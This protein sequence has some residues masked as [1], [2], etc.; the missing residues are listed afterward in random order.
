MDFKR[1]LL[2]VMAVILVSCGEKEDT[3]IQYASELIDAVQVNVS[4]MTASFSGTYKNISKIDVALGRQGILYCEK[5]SDAKELFKSWTEGNLRPECFMMD[6]VS[7]NGEICTGLIGSLMPDTEYSYCFFFQNAD[8]SI[9]KISDVYVFRT[10]LFNPGINNNSVE[11]IHYSD[12]KARCNLSINEADF[13]YITIGVEVSEQ[14]SSSDIAGKHEYLFNGLFN[15]DISVVLDDLKENTDYSFRFFVKYLKEAGRYEYIYGSQCIFRTKNLMNMA[16]DLGLPSG[17]RWAD[18]DLG[19]YEFTVYPQSPVYQWGV[20][21]SL[22]DYNTSIGTELSGTQYDIV[23]HRLGG[24]WRMPT[25]ADVEELISNCKMQSFEEVTIKYTQGGAQLS[26]V[27]HVGKIIGSNGNLIKFVYGNPYWTGTLQSS[28]DTVGDGENG[29]NA[30]SFM[31]IS[32]LDKNNHRVNGTG[33]LEIY[34]EDIVSEFHIRPVWDPNI[35]S[36]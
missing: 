25:R 12:A 1:Y 30:V 7:F 18:C 13:P 31:Y 20:V 16:I 3:E 17:I 15:E 9:R 26:Q 27:K 22:I 23:Q 24:K 14:N 10:L 8:N 19:D 36:E 29:S 33:R 11:E 4:S 21:D 34:N 32:D 28:N 6:K 2:S 35:H 5:S